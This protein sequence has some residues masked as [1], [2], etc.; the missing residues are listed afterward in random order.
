LNW[1]QVKPSKN[2]IFGREL[3]FQER[4]TPPRLVRYESRIMVLLVA[5]MF[6]LMAVVAHEG[7]RT[8]PFF[9]FLLLI[10]WIFH[11]IVTIRLVISG[12]DV[13]SRE[14]RNGTWD[15][16]ILTGI[17][18]RQIFFGKWRAA[19]TRIWKWGVVF[20]ILWMGMA[21]SVAIGD[22][23]YWDRQLYDNWLFTAI[24]PILY[25]LLALL[26][27]GRSRDSAG[28]SKA[29]RGRI[30]KILFVG[31]VVWIV[32]VISPYLVAAYRGSESAGRI[33]VWLLLVVCPLLSIAL[34]T[35]E[36]LTCSL[37]GIAAS[38]VTRRGTMAAMLASIIRVLPSFVAGLA[39][40]GIA[41][42]A[43]ATGDQNDIIMVILLGFAEP[44][45]VISVLGS[46]SSPDTEMLYCL[47]TGFV[48]L[49]VLFVLSLIAALVALRRAE[50][51]Q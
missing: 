1:L 37:L 49:T 26:R 43:F 31:A 40:I 11:M 5:L 20:F 47:A 14:H 16:L 46:S 32:L 48:F 39:V 36:I 12:V 18:K 29:V 7:D 45:I 34:A 8:F 6:L 22:G 33:N 13:I 35:L 41:F 30:S 42:T 25:I 44:E 51:Q 24:C 50:T 17:S 3:I 9:L 21:I 23:R 38:A 15:S 2:P 10:M 27:S 28:K 19:I 4:S